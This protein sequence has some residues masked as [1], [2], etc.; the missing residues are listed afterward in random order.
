M[1]YLD[2][3]TEVDEEY[4]GVLS[5]G[6]H[7]RVSLPGEV[8]TPDYI[9]QLAAFLHHCLEREPDLHQRV[10]QCLQEPLTSDRAAKLLE[11]LA[12]TTSDTVSLTSRYEDPDW[13]KGRLFFLIFRHMLTF[14]ACLTT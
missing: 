1:V 11:L 12:R 5:A 14:L 9:R 8:T 4:F 13:F 3:D 2:D 7:L 10:L 6:T